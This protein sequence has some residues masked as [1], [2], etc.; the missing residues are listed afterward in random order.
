MF[1]IRLHTTPLAKP[2]QQTTKDQKL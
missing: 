2:L 1:N